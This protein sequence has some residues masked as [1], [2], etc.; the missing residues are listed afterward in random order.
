MLRV[1]ELYTSTQGEGQRIGELTQFV[2]FAGCDMRCPGWPCDTQHASDPA[3]WRTESEKFTSHQLAEQIIDEEVMN[4]CYTGGEPFMQPNGDL[5]DLTYM[6]L[7]EGCKFEAFSNGSFIYPDWAL[8][9]VHF[10]MDWKLEGSGEARSHRA[11][12]M[13]NAQALKPTDDIKFVVKDTADLHEALSLTVVLQGQYNVQ[14]GFLVG[15]AWDVIAEADIVEFIKENRPPW[16]LNVQT[17]KFI[18]PADERK[19]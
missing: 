2:R 14:A 13:V 1:N 4:I 17:H 12:R 5:Q 11:E 6:L 19:V 3:I 10:T 9:L 16:R 8:D 18:W 7:E 15:S